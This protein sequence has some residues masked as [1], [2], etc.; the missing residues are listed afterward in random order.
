MKTFSSSIIQSNLLRGLNMTAAGDQEEEGGEDG[1]GGR[2]RR[3]LSTKS[4]AREKE[5]KVEEE[6]DEEETIEGPLEEE[7]KERRK[8]DRMIHVLSSSGAKRHI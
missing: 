8:R 3:R 5:V 1:G 6:E 4:R 2:W 7:V